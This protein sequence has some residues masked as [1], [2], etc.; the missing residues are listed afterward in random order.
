MARKNYLDGTIAKMRIE[1]R[2]QSKIIRFIL[3]LI[4]YFFQRAEQYVLVCSQVSRN[5]PVNNSNEESFFDFLI[6]VSSAIASLRRLCSPELAKWETVSRERLTIESFAIQ[7]IFVVSKFLMLEH[8]ILHCMDWLLLCCGETCGRTKNR[9]RWNFTII[10]WPNI[11]VRSMIMANGTCCC[12]VII[13]IE[14]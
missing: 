3:L 12:R 11:I 1:S 8:N 13:I 7:S 4:A 6:F 2:G 9:F 5:N 10:H 14:V